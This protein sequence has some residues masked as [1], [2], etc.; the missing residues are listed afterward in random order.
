MYYYSDENE[1][2]HLFR[3]KV[4]MCCALRVCSAASDFNKCTISCQWALSR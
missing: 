2:V 4:N 1:T 3:K